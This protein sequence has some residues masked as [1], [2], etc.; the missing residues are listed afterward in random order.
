MNLMSIYFQPLYQVAPALDMLYLFMMAFCV[1][2][3]A[4]AI[5]ATNVYEE[6]SLGI[7]H[8]DEQSPKDGLFNLRR[9]TGYSK[10]HLREQLAVSG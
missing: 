1:Y 10:F 8:D 6:R 2:P 7:A 5:R 3:L 9:E 4:L